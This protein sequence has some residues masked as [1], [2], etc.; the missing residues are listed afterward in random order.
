VGALPRA[1]QETLYAIDL[2]RHGSIDTLVSR[3]SA[4][5]TVY[6][7]AA[8]QITGWAIDRVA[9][10]E[11][12]GVIAL[13]DGDS[14]V[15]AKYGISRP[16][17]SRALGSPSYEMSGFEVTIDTARLSSVPHR[18]SFVI[19]DR[20]KS[21]YYSVRPVIEIEVKERTAL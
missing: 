10:A 19:V 17:V 7:G 5:V 21:S 11:A 18:I 9:Q 12:G 6:R 8:M 13:V 1:R 14:A 3:M 20:A 15:R 2:V 4:P 16:D